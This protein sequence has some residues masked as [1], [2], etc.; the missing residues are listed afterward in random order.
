MLICKAKSSL[1]SPENQ[2]YD[3]ISQGINSVERML[4]VLKSLKIRAPNCKILA[5]CR[6]NNNKKVV[7][8]RQLIWK[9]QTHLQNGCAHC[10]IFSD[11]GGIGRLSKHRC[12]VIH[13]LHVDIH[14]HRRTERRRRTVIRRRND[15]NVVLRSLV[16]QLGGEREYTGGGVQGED[17]L[18][19]LCDQVV[20]DVGVGAFV[21]VHGGHLTHLASLHSHTR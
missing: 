5:E 8:E 16:V 18:A 14:S 19:P 11:G 13:I 9:T 6:Y 10:H 15:K 7:F 20:G 17:L 4:V 12:I 1:S 3:R 21:A 2:F